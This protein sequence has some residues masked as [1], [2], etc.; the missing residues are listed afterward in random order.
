LSRSEYLG[1]SSC[2]FLDSTIFHV[3]KLKDAC[4]FSEKAREPITDVLEAMRRADSAGRYALVFRQSQEGAVEV[5]I[6]YVQK[7]EFVHGFRCSY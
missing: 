6:S 5:N 3:S 2:S 7:F 1:T 4:E